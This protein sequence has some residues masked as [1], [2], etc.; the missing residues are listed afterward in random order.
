VVKICTPLD[1]GQSYM[2][3]VIQISCV[4]DLVFQS[5]NTILCT[6]RSQ[7][8]QEYITDVNVLKMYRQLYYQYYAVIFNTFCTDSIC[9]SYVYTLL[10]GVRSEADVARF[11]YQ[12][13]SRY[14]KGAA[15]I[16]TLLEM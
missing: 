8:D 6:M 4:L 14:L 15:R 16:L 11:C 13:R 5:S 9:C 10:G 3:H 2:C 7:T 12:T 1:I